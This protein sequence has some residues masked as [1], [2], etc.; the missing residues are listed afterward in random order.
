VQ[1]IPSIDI[2]NRLSSYFKVAYQQTNIDNHSS[3]A[4]LRQ[5]WHHV[6]AH[7]F[8]KIDYEEM[9]RIYYIRSFLPN[10]PQTAINNTD[11]PHPLFLQQ[12]AFADSLREIFNPSYLK[13]LS[14][15]GQ[16]DN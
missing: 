1:P 5:F 11:S 14:E 10:Y 8:K 16:V 7:Y 15:E 9:R 3:D 2:F 4:L 12:P 6:Y 13:Q